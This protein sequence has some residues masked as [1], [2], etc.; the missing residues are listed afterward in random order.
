MSKNVTTKTIR[1]F[2]VHFF[3]KKEK[4]FSTILNNYLTNA[5]KIFNIIVGFENFICKYRYQITKNRNF[6][7]RIVNKNYVDYFK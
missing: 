4:I 2:Q 6:P 3:Q 7:W 5:V 1:F